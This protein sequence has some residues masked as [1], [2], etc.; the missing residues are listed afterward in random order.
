MDS[1]SFHLDVISGVGSL[2][3]GSVKSVRVTGSEG[4]MGIRYG[5]TPLLTTIKTGMVSLIDSQDK[6]DQIYLA[7]GVLEVQPDSVTILADTALR[8]DDIDEAK[9][10][11]AIKVAK[12]SI[13][14]HGTGDADYAHA[15]SRLADAMARLKVVET[16]RNR[17]R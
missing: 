10:Q 12:E 1:I 2:Y 4:E 8:A 7:G 14:N 13:A 9:A 17:R 3:S 16:A 6:E 5:H 15:L 11:E